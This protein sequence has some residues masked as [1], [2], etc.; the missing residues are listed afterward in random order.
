MR[1]CCLTLFILG[2]LSSQ[3]QVPGFLGKRFT[4]FLDANPSPAIFAQSTSNKLMVDLEG[5]THAA[6]TN[7]FA[8]NTRPQVTV[9]YQF[10]KRHSIGLSYNRLSFGTTRGYY[11]SEPVEGQEYSYEYDSDVVRGDAFGV[12]LKFYYSTTVAPIGYYQTLSVYYSRVN[13]FDDK[14]SSTRQFRDDFKYPTVTMQLGRQSM[15]LKNLLVR[16]GFEM[17][18]T[19]VPSNFLTENNG[20]WSAQEFSGYKVHQGLMGYYFFNLTLGVGYVLF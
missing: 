14:K 17:G 13:T 12:H 16:A 9:E 19:F 3:A 6:T 1:L 15:P 5:E 11:R 2:A 10:F 18:W 7:Q 4:V 8:F 20:D